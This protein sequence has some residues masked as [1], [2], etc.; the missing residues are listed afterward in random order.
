MLSNK[1]HSRSS[2]SILS[3]YS[4]PANAAGLQSLVP[5]AHLLTIVITFLL[6]WKKT[7]N[8]GGKKERHGKMT[9]T[10]ETLAEVTVE[11]EVQALNTQPSGRPVHQIADKADI[12]LS[13]FHER[14]ISEVFLSIAVVVVV[15]VSLL[16]YVAS[17]ISLVYRQCGIG[18][19]HW[20][21]LAACGMGLAADT[22]ELL[23]LGFVLPSAE[24]DFCISQTEKRVLG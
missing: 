19:F 13:E 5:S 12:A 23:V 11:E 8:W 3:S 9:N 7:F 22:A 2:T 21:L 16:N 20:I 10:E 14:A 15:V 4:F 1:L 18:R 24:V 6:R 17:W